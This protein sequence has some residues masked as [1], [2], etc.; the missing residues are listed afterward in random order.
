VFV[1]YCVG[2][3]SAIRRPKSRL[4]AIDGDDLLWRSY[5]QKTNETILE[6][7]LALSSIQGL[8]WVGVEDPHYNR[9]RFITSEG[10]SHTLPDEFFPASHR[11][12]IE[13][14]LKE[15]VPGLEI[16][17]RVEFEENINPV[18]TTQERRLP[19]LPLRIAGPVLV[20]FVVLEGLAVWF[21]FRFESAWPCAPILFVLLLVGGTIFYHRRR[22]P[23]CRTRLRLRYDYTGTKPFYRRVYDCPHCRITWDWEKF[24]TQ[25]SGETNPSVLHKGVSVEQ[26]AEEALS[27]PREA[28]AYSG[29]LS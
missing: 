21:S 12:K 3:I 4:L 24:T 9:L 20:A 18:Q 26:I 29:S 25:V 23:E 27:L 22:C 11:N 16:M 14:A 15:R 1:L 8:K 7:R 17:E 28:R 6:K 13:T 5:S 19:K 10:V 2:A